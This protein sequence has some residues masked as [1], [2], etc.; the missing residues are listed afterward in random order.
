YICAASRQYDLAQVMAVV[1]ELQQLRRR[2]AIGRADR[3]AAMQHKYMPFGIERDARNFA[4]VEVGR[5]AQE[6][7]NGLIGDRRDFFGAGEGG[8]RQAQSASAGGREKSPATPGAAQNFA[9][10]RAGLRRTKMH[11]VLPLVAGSTL[12]ALPAG[13]RSHPG[14]LQRYY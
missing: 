13:N 14:P 12:R 9:A 3:I 5:Q 2:R 6:T 7:G 4:E 8:E 11:G 10:A 1:V